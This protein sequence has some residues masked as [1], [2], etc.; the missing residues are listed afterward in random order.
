MRPSWPD[1][2]AI[3]TTL[4]PKAHNSPLLCETPWDLIFARAHVVD[5]RPRSAVAL[6]AGCRSHVVFRLNCDNAQLATP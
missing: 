3:A 4:N 1:A 2:C 6:G 5:G